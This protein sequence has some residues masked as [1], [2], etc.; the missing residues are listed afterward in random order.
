MGCKSL[1]ILILSTYAPAHSANLGGDMMDALQSRGHNVDFVCRYSDSKFEGI[2]HRAIESHKPTLKTILKSYF[3]AKWIEQLLFFFNKLKH[4]NRNKKGLVYPNEAKPALNP[5]K[6]I[7][8]VGSQKY[9]LIITLFWVDM[10]NSTT[11][12]FFYE[13]YKCPILI[14]SVDMAPMTGGCY[15]FNECN[16]FMIGCG[17]CNLLDKPHCKDQSN[18]NYKIK[19]YNYSTINCSF[20]GNTWMNSYAAQSGL[21]EKNKIYNASVVLDETIFSPGSQIDAKKE[22]GVPLDKDFI[23]FARSWDL[24]RKRP[25]YI[26]QGVHDLWQTLDSIQRS[27]FF[28]ITVGDNKIVNEL[29]K[30]DIPA[31]N[32]GFV[33]KEKLILLYRSATFFL[34][35]STDDAGPSMVNQSIMCG[36]PVISFNNGTAMDV[37]S[38][39]ISGFKTNEISASGFSSTLKEAYNS[40]L[41]NQ[42]PVIRETTRNEALKHCSKKTFVDR[43]ENIYNQS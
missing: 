26:I 3:R 15:Y 36:T 31:F 8:Y 9:D 7:N 38:N 20:I 1:K 28:I 41:K 12:K 4:P 2:T 22:L 39:G 40:W 21:F 27:R 18:T 30:F 24:K 19:K 6:L 37:I 16:N 29:S 11:L 17:N 35:A 34:S 32:F 25:E 33:N 10:I 43:I 13:K 42:F 14:Y 5:D 23:L